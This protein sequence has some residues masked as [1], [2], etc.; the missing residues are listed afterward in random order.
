MWQAE[1]QYSV[2]I[3][4][5]SFVAKLVEIIESILAMIRWCMNCIF[6][7]TRFDK[8]TQFRSKPWSDMT[9]TRAGNIITFGVERHNSNGGNNCYH[10][11]LKLGFHK[12]RHSDPYFTPQLI[13]QLTVKANNDTMNDEGGVTT[14]NKFEHYKIKYLDGNDSR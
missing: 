12:D 13:F 2:L 10:G 6:G 8:R 3:W 4:K 7:C 14:R 5:N 9:R 11:L 1:I